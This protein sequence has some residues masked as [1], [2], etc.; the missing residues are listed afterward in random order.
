M[1]AYIKEYKKTAC[2]MS[3]KNTGEPCPRLDMVLRS[4][5]I[6]LLQ[7]TLP[8]SLLAILITQVRPKPDHHCEIGPISL[9]INDFE[10]RDIHDCTQDNPF[11]TDEIHLLL[12]TTGQSSTNGLI[13]GCSPRVQN[14]STALCANSL[15]D[16]FGN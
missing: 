11:S 4:Q 10:R 7:R 5:R 3:Q 15:S 9:T 2:L 14:S 1:R 13:T 8:L 12:S 6:G 16:D